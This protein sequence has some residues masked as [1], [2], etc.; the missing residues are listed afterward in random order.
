MRYS[1]EEI[2]DVYSESASYEAAA[3]RLGVSRDTVG[4]AVRRTGGQR[5]PGS[6]RRYPVRDDAFTELDPEAAYW[7]GFIVADGSVEGGCRLR[8][9]LGYRDAPH[10]HALAAYLGCPKKPLYR[11]GTCNELVFTSQQVVSDLRRYGILERKSWVN[12]TVAPE[13]L[14]FPSFLLGLFD[15]DGSAGCHLSAVGAR[16]APR[17]RFYG[18]EA[19]LKQWAP[20]IGELGGCSHP[21][22]VR[23]A[24]KQLF[25]TKVSG[26]RAQALLRE[27]YTSSPVWLPRKRSTAEAIWRWAPLPLGPPPVPRI[28]IA[29]ANCGGTV[30]KT[31]AEIA[32]VGVKGFFC[33]PDCWQASRARPG[34]LLDVSAERCRDTGPP[35]I[36]SQ[37]LAPIVDILERYDPAGAGLHYA[38]IAAQLDYEGRQFSGEPA[39]I[40]ATLSQTSDRFRGLGHRSGLYALN[41]TEAA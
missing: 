9:N 27:L 25:E 19:L 24:H 37:L 10:Q 30:E 12:F 20:A 34:R 41:I 4:K 13:L 21:P 16:P 1:D 28:A 17:V 15:G 6:W 35:M 29:C 38:D 39:A 32:V 3:L 36:G 18:A 8:V 7:I 26:A 2:A 40:I 5:G 31:Q 14:A 22:A 11:N 33:S 23:R